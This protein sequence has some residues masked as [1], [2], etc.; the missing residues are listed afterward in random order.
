MT[1]KYILPEKDLL[2]KD[3]TMKRLEYSPLGKE[4]TAQTDITK[5]QHQKLDNTCELDKTNKWIKTKNQHLKTIVN[6]I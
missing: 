6:Q 1:G 2:D 3:A 5:K 4:L